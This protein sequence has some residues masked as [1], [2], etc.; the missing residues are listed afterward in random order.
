MDL[1]QFPTSFDFIHKEGMGKSNF[2]KKM[3]ERI[4]R[5]IQQQIER[6][7]KYNNKGK[8]EMIFEERD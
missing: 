6:Y 8:R 7:I 1:L 5:Q 2:V 4:K 3:H